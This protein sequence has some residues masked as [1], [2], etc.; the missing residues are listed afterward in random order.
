[1]ENEQTTKVSEVDTV[2]GW[3]VTHWTKTWDTRTALTQLD[4]MI[5]RAST[6]FATAQANLIDLEAKKQEF[7]TEIAAAIE[8]K[9]L[10][11]EEAERLSK[12]RKDAFAAG[13]Q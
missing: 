11:D 13:T 12:E 3:L 6:A 2:G 5:S 7:E 9:R 8:Q 1:M 10:A 4:E